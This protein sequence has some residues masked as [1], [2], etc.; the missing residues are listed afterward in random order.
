[1]WTFWTSWQTEGLHL[2]WTIHRATTLPTYF[3]DVHW[4]PSSD[5]VSIRASSSYR[6]PCA[7][8]HPEW[9]PLF[10]SITLNHWFLECT[11]VI[12]VK[13]ATDFSCEMMH[14]SNQFRKQILFDMQL[15]TGYRRMANVV[16][17]SCQPRTIFDNIHDQMLSSM[18]SSWTCVKQMP[19]VGGCNGFNVTW[20]HA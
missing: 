16:I 14:T 1:M 20:M 4:S 11:V 15:K 6:T 12:V 10:I 9:A 5:S 8:K 2:Q 17:H 13:L 7:S 19:R 18:K 3:H